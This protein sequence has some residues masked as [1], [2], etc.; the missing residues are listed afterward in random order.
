[1]SGVGK[2]SPTIIEVSSYPEGHLVEFQEAI[3]EA[4]DL[5]R[6]GRNEEAW[7]SYTT[8]VALLYSAEMVVGLGLVRPL[9]KTEL[10]DLARAVFPAQVDSDWDGS[11]VQ[12]ADAAC[13]ELI[14][15]A[16]ERKFAFRAYSVVEMFKSR[17][18]MRET[19]ARELASAGVEVDLIPPHGDFAESEVDFILSSSEKTTAILS[20]Y[21]SPNN[22]TLHVFAAFIGPAGLTWHLHSIKQSETAAILEAA[23]DYLRAWQGRSDLG[24]AQQ[25]LR[26]TLDL[27]GSQLEPQLEL[28]LRHKVEKLILVPHGVLHQIPLHACRSRADG[29]TLPIVEMFESV[30]FAPSLTLLCAV[31]TNKDVELWDW[32]ILGSFDL[33]DLTHASGLFAQFC[34]SYRLAPLT[35]LQDPALPAVEKHL[36]GKTVVHFDCHGISNEQ[37]FMESRLLLASSSLSFEQILD[38]YSFD[39]TQLVFLNACQTGHSFNPETLVDEYYGLDGAVLAKGALNVIST[40][41]NVNDCAALL[42]ACKF[43]GYLHEEKLDVSTALQLAQLWL[44]DGKWKSDDRVRLL[45][46]IIG[47]TASKVDSST[48]RRLLKSRDELRDFISTRSPDTF[49]SEIHWAAWKCSGFGE[50]VIQYFEMTYGPAELG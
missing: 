21:I 12:L 7:D 11:L 2:K 28:L 40:F 41:N 32:S 14:D 26:S 15:F 34:F 47:I 1:M 50:S 48:S 17:R 31:A 10:V 3:F 35:L 19:K 18:L 6:L 44:R 36:K 39:R 27:L 8:A 46:N 49:A 13:Y 42:L 9:S 20:F 22:V 4:R 25:H 45:V 38:S 33:A 16:L 5:S 37:D 43:Y 29:K 30:T 23:R 24:K